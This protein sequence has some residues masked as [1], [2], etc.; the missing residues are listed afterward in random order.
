MTTTAE[1]RTMLDTLERV[2][3]TPLAELADNLAGAVD[4]VVARIVKSHVDDEV[5]VAAFGSSI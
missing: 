5:P 3:R 2:G 4:G 1:P